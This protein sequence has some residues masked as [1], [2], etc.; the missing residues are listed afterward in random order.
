MLYILDTDH[1]SLLQQKNAIV[2]AHLQQ[3]TVE[4]RAVT[5]ISAAEQIQG[6]MAVISQAKSEIDAARGFAR[7][8]ETIRFYQT[9]QVVPYD[10]ADA[11]LF[12][13]LRHAKIRI[14]R[15]DLRIA[16]IAL[17]L[18]AT[19]VTRNRRDFIQVPGLSIVDW[20]V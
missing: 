13:Q 4:E 19:L 1:I 20:S 14:G 7:L 10:I 9:V 15:Q 6:R 12:D 3:A 11:T 18:N 17:N 16:S 8:M 2:W 5:V